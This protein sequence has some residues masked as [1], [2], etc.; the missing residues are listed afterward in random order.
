MIWFFF[1]FAQTQLQILVFELCFGRSG[2]LWVHASSLS[3]AP[4]VFCFVFCNILPLNNVDFSCLKTI[5]SLI[6]ILTP[7]S[8]VLIKVYIRFYTFY[9][10]WIFWFF[11]IR[12]Y[13]DV[14]KLDSV[15][16]VYGK[17]L[18][19][20]HLDNCHYCLKKLHLL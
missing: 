13:S 17:K 18:G 1:S 5:S 20:W 4:S 3:S 14:D 7:I 10:E 8:V 19:F 11:C 16:F 2:E 6:P 9:S 15:N 12:F